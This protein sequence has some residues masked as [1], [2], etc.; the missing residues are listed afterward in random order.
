MNK[1]SV[2]VSMQQNVQ[3]GHTSTGHNSNEAAYGVR[4][5]WSAIGDMAAA[6]AGLSKANSFMTCRSWLS[7]SLDVLSPEAVMKCVPSLLSCMSLMSASCILF[8][9]V[10]LP[11]C[12][13]RL[14]VK[15][16]VKHAQM[17]LLYTW[18]YIWYRNWTD[19]QCN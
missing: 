9:A 17:P 10:I 4:L 14:N 1:Q 3:P 19:G 12:T 7:T 8:S 11:V 2:Q 13:L 15:Y 5:T 18:H 6:L 16:K